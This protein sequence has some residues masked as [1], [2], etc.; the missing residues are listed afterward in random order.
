MVFIT[1]LRH[2]HFERNWQRRLFLLFL[3]T[4]A[5][6]GAAAVVHDAPDESVRPVVVARQKVVLKVA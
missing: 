3:R 5:V 1:F 2:H 4:K 6:V